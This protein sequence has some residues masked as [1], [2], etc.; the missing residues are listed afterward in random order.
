M[1]APRQLTVPLDDATIAD[2]RAGDLVSLTGALY[3]AR[4]AAHRR[5][6]DLIETGEELPIELEGQVIYYC[7]PSPAPPGRPI[8][9]AGPTTASRMDRFAPDLH[10]LGLKGTIGKGNRSTQVRLALMRYQAVY[11]AGVGGAGALLADCVRSARVIAYEDLGPEAIRL[12]EVVD[13]PLVVGY[14]AHGGTAFAGEEPI[15]SGE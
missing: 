6:M 3:T 1:S 9:A 2:L 8:G 4:D 5:L 15:S 7:G 11:F 10:R 13:L 14:D 12:L